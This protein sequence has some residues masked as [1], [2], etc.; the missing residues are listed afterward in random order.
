[1]P[2]FNG[3]LCGRSLPAKGMEKAGESWLWKEISES[4]SLQTF[5]LTVLC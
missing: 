3:E 1:M 2:T 4:V 5:T